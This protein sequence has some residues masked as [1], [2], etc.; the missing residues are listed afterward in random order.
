MIL[1]EEILDITLEIEEL[2][3]ELHR[4]DKKFY[5]NIK[6]HNERRMLLV[7][8]LVPYS[9]GDDIFLLNQNHEGWYRLEEIYN[10]DS[11]MKNGELII[12]IQLGIRVIGKKRSPIGR[13]YEVRT[14][15]NKIPALDH[16]ND[17]VVLDVRK[18]TKLSDSN[19]V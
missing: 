4:L 14:Y 19:T 1:L 12:T 8:S 9:I 15:I 10:V 3:N 2:R 16:Y 13:S 6:K 5:Y 17:A 7:K 11:G 18:N